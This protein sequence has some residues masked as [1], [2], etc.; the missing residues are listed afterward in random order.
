MNAIYFCASAVTMALATHVILCTMLVQILGPGLALNG[1]IGSMAKATEGMKIEQKQI[2]RSFFLMMGS[3]SITTV[4]LFWVTMDF[5]SSIVSTAFFFFAA[6][7]WAFYCS[8]IRARFFWN[9]TN[10]QAGE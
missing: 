10:N 9:D 5:Y 8:R 6:R 7:Q 4:L 3:F 2:V 1:P